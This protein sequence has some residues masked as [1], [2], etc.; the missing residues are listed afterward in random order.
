MHVLRVYEYYSLGNK[1]SCGFILVQTR[2]PTVGNSLEKF[3]IGRTR[4]RSRPET[5]KGP[6][7]K[8][9][10]GIYLI[11]IPYWNESFSERSSGPFDCPNCVAHM[12]K[13]F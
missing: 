8:M 13:Q 7:Q 2:I 12:D 10:T 9:Y 3:R 6:P 11:N 1:E 4:F 5:Q